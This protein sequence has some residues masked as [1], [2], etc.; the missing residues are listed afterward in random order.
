M[1]PTGWVP[2]TQV[3]CIT[4]QDPAVTEAATSNQGGATDDYNPFAEEAKKDVEVS[5]SSNGVSSCNSWVIPSLSHSC[6]SWVIPS[7]PTAVI[8]GSSL[9]PTFTW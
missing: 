6:N 8:V 4:P 3:H 9:P 2:S 5:V 7:P 1:E